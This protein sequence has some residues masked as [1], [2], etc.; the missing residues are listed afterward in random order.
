[1]SARAIGDLPFWERGAPGPLSA[2][3]AWRQ[4]CAERQAARE[5]RLENPNTNAASRDERADKRALY[6]RRRAAGQCVACLAP[7]AGAR[8]RECALE[9][10]AASRRG[11]GLK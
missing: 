10:A 2:W 8:C 4:E 9:D 6:R 1:M 7:A 5:R 11:R 3:D